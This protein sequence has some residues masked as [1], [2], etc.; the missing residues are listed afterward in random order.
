MQRH[1]RLV[2]KPGPKARQEAI[3]KRQEADQRRKAEGFVCMFGQ[4]EISMISFDT[5]NLGNCGKKKVAQFFQPGKL[6][7]NKAGWGLRQH[8]TILTGKSGYRSKEIL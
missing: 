7:K 5:R 2:F 8:S 3:A 4:L 1:H 6:R